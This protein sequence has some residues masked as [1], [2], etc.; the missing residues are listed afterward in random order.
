MPSAARSTTSPTATTRRRR[1]ARRWP[2]GAREVDRDLRRHAAPAAWRACW[3]ASPRITGSAARISCASSTAWRWT[4][5]ADIRAPSLE[6]LDL[7]CDC[8][9]SAVG[10]LS[11]RIFGDDGAAADRVAMGFGPRAPAHQHPARPRRGRRARPP[12]SAARAVA[13]ARHHR[14]RAG[15]RARR[16]ARGASLRRSRRDRR[17]ALCRGHA[18]RC[19]LPAPRDAARRGD[20]G[21]SIAPRSSGCAGAAGRASTSPRRC[22]AAPSSGSR[23]ATGCCERSRASM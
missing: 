1:S 7:Y 6:Q 4:R 15:D 10:R 12:L 9:A 13:A 21:R 22:R 17:G 2:N 11:V 19:A 16:S 23:C 5:S 14:E 3:R 20:G 18:R 8:V